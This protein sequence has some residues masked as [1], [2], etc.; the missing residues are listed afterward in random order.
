MDSSR[1]KQETSE[2]KEGNKKRRAEE[3]QDKKNGDVE[4]YFW[5]RIGKLQEQLAYFKTEERKSDLK[6][7]RACKPSSRRE[8]EGKK[9]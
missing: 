1:G 6:K 5:D 8:R 2:R 3:I 4:S 7:T 9:I